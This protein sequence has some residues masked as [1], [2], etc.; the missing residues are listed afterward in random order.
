MI[1]M[2]NAYD[3]NR[4]YK[5]P[6]AFQ[7]PTSYVA[8]DLETTGREIADDE[9]IQIGAVKIIN[10]E[11]HDEFVTYV[12][13]DRKIDQEAYEVN[14]IS[15][16][17][18]ADAPMLHEVAKAFLDFIEDLPLVGQ[19]INRFDRP[20]LY[21][22]FARFE[23]LAIQDSGWYD[24]VD[25]YRQFH[26]GQANLQAICEYY[27]IINPRAHDALG[28]ALTSHKCYWAIREEAAALST[29]VR[30]IQVAIID[31]SLSN[32][33]IVFTN[34]SERLS[35]HGAEE[36]AKAHGATIQNGIR[37]KDTTL[38][39][40]LTGVHTGKVEKAERYGIRVIDL[41]EFLQLI[42]Q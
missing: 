42:A 17:M 25:L 31:N 39:V 20:I 6:K 32:E 21:H 2:E 14:R 8:F 9:I 24:T 29:D 38:L 15:Q 34:D 13:T 1:N 30:D 23:D 16:A 22:A 12:Y 27:G 5:A 19:N 33:F 35:Q 4:S 37:K 26:S 18:I 28:D 41:D 7:L 40:N 3:L 11:V 36:L 10:G